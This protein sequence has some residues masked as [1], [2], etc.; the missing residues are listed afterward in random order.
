[1]FC[2]NSTMVRLKGQ[3]HK[4]LRESN[5]MFQFHYG[6]IKS[7]YATCMQGTFHSFNSTMVRLKDNGTSQTSIYT[8]RFNSTMVR[9]KV[10][11]LQSCCLILVS[12]NSTMVR[13]KALLLNL[14]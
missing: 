3:S 11:C 4:G 8:H 6:T 12:F 13:L 10:R 14:L 9:L 1:M 5:F 2:F 7:S